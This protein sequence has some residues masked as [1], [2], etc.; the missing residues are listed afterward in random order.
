MR[1]VLQAEATLTLDI[2][3]GR[4]LVRVVRVMPNVGDREY[5]VLTSDGRAR[6]FVREI[7]VGDAIVVVHGG[8][9]FDQSY[10]SPELDRLRDTF[11]LVYYDQRGRGRSAQ[12][13]SAA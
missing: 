11:R 10:L 3:P 7:G 12:G 4:A 8:P 13:V 2:A 6:L 1:G 9:D 5:R